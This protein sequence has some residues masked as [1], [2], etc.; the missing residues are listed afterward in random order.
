MSS[1]ERSVPS[2]NIS[3]WGKKRRKINSEWVSMIG[4]LRGASIFSTCLASPLSTALTAEHVRDPV[5]GLCTLADV[6]EQPG[7]SRQL[8]GGFN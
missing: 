7:V 6:R 5:K 4:T 3:T 8:Q 1:G 2:S